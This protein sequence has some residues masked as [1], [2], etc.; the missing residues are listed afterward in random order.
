MVVTEL[1]GPAELE[2]F[3][4]EDYAVVDCYGDFCAACEMLEPVFEA[5]ASCMP[6][7]RFGRINVC[8]HMEL[9]EKFGISAFPTLLFFRGGR[10]VH[11]ALGSMDRE[12]LDAQLAIML[13][14]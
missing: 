10:E 8:D 6:G 5:A 12:A 3:V 7:I 4:D 14:Q 9:T 11:R 13:Y 1:K 2:A